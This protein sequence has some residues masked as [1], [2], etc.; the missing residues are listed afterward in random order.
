M[1][2]KVFDDTNFYGDDSSMSPLASDLVII[3]LDKIIPPAGFQ[4]K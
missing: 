3:K 1:K 4:E 2:A